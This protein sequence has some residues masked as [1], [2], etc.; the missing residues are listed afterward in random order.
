[1]RS[2][3][4]IEVIGSFSDFRK[5]IYWRIEMKNLWKLI[6]L[7]LLATIMIVI[8]ALDMRSNA[9]AEINEMDLAFQELKIGTTPG[10]LAPDFE[11]ETLNGETIHLSEFRGKIVL[12]NVFASWCG[13]CRLEMPHL[14]ITFE[15][16]NSDEFAF[17]G[18]NLQETPEAVAQFRREFN[19]NFP[20]IINQQGDLTSGLF[21]P[22]G[23]PTTWFVD[24]QGVVRYVYS[25]AMTD[26]I[27]LR[28]LEDVE[29]GIEPDPFA[30][31][32]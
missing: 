23:L 11:G 32:E 16:L 2:I 14:V 26:E 25:G 3:F 29:A 30:I 1:M 13:P 19:I 7:V 24:S 15:Q 8:F 12:I 4:F 27:L 20:L 10:E 18:I 9:R 6:V 22:I 28:I 21:K 31:T 17:I 5:T